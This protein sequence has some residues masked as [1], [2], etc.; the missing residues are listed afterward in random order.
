M[1]IKHIQS[2]LAK[3]ATIFQ[4]G[5]FRPT[6]G[7]L[8]SWIGYV[9]WSLLE[10]DRPSDFQPLAT[11]F[12]KDLPYVPQALQP[13]QLVTLFVHENIFDHLMEDD[14]STYFEIR[15]YTTLENLVQ[16]DWQH[17]R[18]RAFPLQAKHIHNDYPVWDGGGIPAQIEE[19]ILRLEHEEGLNYFD[20][21]LEDL[22]PQHKIG[23]YP[24]FC[25]SGYE[26][27]ED[28]PFVFQ[29]ASDAKAQLNIVDNGNFYFFY[30]PTEQTWRAYCDFY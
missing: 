20:D 26:F 14:L 22:Y 16:R 3:Q 13:F 18:I 1:S 15:V 11:L 12:L 2:Q 23:G 28:T 29:I 4:T 19:D 6:H 24:T 30:N 10:E 27:G 21:I 7:L 9:G 5:G 8:E 17:D 25:Q